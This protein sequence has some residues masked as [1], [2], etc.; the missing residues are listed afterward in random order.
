MA[1]KIFDKENDEYM[2]DDAFA[3]KDAARDFITTVY[4]YDFDADT[5]GMSHDE[6]DAQPL[7]TIA[8]AA[9]LEIEEV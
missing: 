5:V 6:W 1:Y 2:T 7:E 9:H 3:T 4:H 8:E